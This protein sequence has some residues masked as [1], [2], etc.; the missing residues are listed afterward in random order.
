MEAKHK[1]SELKTDYDKDIEGEQSLVGRLSGG[2]FIHIQDD[3]EEDDGGS[4]LVFPPTEKVTSEDIESPADTIK[5]ERYEKAK[6]EYV[7]QLS[8][9][10]NSAKASPE[11]K[12]MMESYHAIGL[13]TDD[14]DIKT[15]RKKL[16]KGLKQYTGQTGE[17]SAFRGWSA[18]A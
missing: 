1:F 10:R 6:E 5:R 7:E 2:A 18:R 17:E 4:Y 15:H 16:M 13:K 11:Y 8:E 3:G 12:H 9:L 14:I